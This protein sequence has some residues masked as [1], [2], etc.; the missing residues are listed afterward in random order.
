MEE[1]M[2]LFDSQ[3]VNRIAA[4]LGIL[5][6]GFVSGVSNP[7]LAATNQATGNI[8]GD[9]NDLQDSN[10]FTINSSTLALVKA[11]FLPDSTLLADGS[12]VPAGTEVQFLIY[13]DNDTDLQIDD[14]NI[15]D[16]L[17]VDFVYQSPSLKIDNSQATGAALNDIY[18]AVVGTANINDAVEA[19]D[20]AGVSGTVV[21]AG[22][23]AGNA[24]LN[25]PANTVWAMLF[26]VEVQ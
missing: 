23:T 11:A 20:E 1:A 18:L 8:A 21:S 13:V 10:I 17:G 15:A 7:A 12:T 6:I 25:V 14:I 2:R 19:G 5:V 4:I 24:P 26:T 22:S 16:D 9:P 3:A